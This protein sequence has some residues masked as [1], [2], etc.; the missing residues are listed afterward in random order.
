MPHP[1][2][3]AGQGRVA[4]GDGAGLVATDGRGLAAGG[5]AAV[6]VD[7]LAEEAARGVALALVTAAL[8]VDATAVP[9]GSD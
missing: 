8:G 9:V 7:G 6:R 4:D 5:W 2:V 1:D 3:R